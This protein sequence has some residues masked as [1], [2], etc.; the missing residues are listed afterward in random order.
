M[1]PIA[2]ELPC[3][4]TRF[5]ELPYVF[6]FGVELDDAAVA[7]VCDEDVAARVDGHRVGLLEADFG[8]FIGGQTGG[9]GGGFNPF[10]GCPF[11]H[12]VVLNVGDE[13]L[14]HGPTAT[15]SGLENCPAPEP[16]EPKVAMK[17]PEAEN[18]CTRF[19]HEWTGNNDGWLT[20]MGRWLRA[21]QQVRRD[22]AAE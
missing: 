17:L 18:S 20:N 13:D 1:P 11:L 16:A 14:A 19:A 21:R 4:R 12:A 7:R 5:A 3:P 9:V 15:P 10:G 6:A 8:V 2:P 22:V